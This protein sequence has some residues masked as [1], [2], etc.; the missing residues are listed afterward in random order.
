MFSKFHRVH[1]CHRWT[2]CLLDDKLGQK[3]YCEQLSKIVFSFSS[4]WLDRRVNW[5]QFSPATTPILSHCAPLVFAYNS[6][7]EGWTC[8]FHP[9]L[10]C[11]EKPFTDNQCSSTF[12]ELQY[13]N[14][15]FLKFSSSQF[16][17]HVDAKKSPII[18]IAATMRA[19]ART[20]HTWHVC[21]RLIHL[22]ILL[23]AMMV[24]KH[25]NPT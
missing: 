23:N 1:S 22:P 20:P 5:M 8:L 17:E 9:T 6:G 11:M 10:L 25:P 12:G 21:N 19:T 15:H 18:P 16:S 2:P 24:L 13:S 7:R 3:W 4:A 14:Y